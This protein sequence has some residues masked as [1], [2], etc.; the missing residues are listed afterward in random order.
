MDSTA[1]HHRIFRRLSRNVVFLLADSAVANIAS[2]AILLILARGYWPAVVGQVVTLMTIA[3]VGIL[4]GDL[5]NGQASTLLISRHQAGMGGPS[6][7]RTAAAGL[8]Q[9]AVGGCVLGVGVLF[10]P[11]AI[12]WLAERFGQADRAR[13]IAALHDTIHLVAVWVF[14]A[15][16]LQQTA[17]VFAGFQKMQYTLIQDVAT[18]IPRLAI[19]AAAVI[20][21]WEWRWIIEG[22]AGWFIVA[23]TVGLVLVVTIVRRAGERFSL[24]GYRPLARLRTGAVLFTPIAAGFIL[25][26]LAIAIIWWMN[27][28]EMGYR[29]VGFFAP[30]WTLTRGYE[31]LLMPLA[32]ALLPAVSDAH[33][34][35]DPAVL[36]S[37]ARR[38]LLATGLAS[39]GILILFVA[40][41]HLF[42]GLFGA[43]YAGFV[44][45]F[46]VLAFGVAFESQR[47]ALDPLL[48][49]S[50]LARWVTAIDWMKFALLAGLAIPL[51]GYHYL[52]G[53]SVAFVG[54][55]VPAWAAKVAL[56]HFRLRVR[57]LAPAAGLAALLGATIGAA[58]LLRS[59]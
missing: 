53:M 52:T 46:M 35:R 31:V 3:S 18:Q 10:L 51:F 47:C 30:L 12:E 50:G 17:G 4:L 40:V 36:T 24:A 9:A 59:L 55:F 26:Y 23:A 25:Q 41:P 1:P 27:T 22:W 37:L 43:E 29:S 49:G 39:V 38:S 42:L 57:I 6:P 58:L 45:P 33:G 20:L 56:I 15:T 21:A 8:V 5:G 13:E 11:D 34:T 19:C 7:G 28:G 2:F 54:A 44:L 14:L 32:T 48:N 16:L